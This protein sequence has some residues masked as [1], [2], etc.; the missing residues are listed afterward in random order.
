L[1]LSSEFRNQNFAIIL[2]EKIFKK[3]NSVKKFSFSF[4]KNSQKFTTIA[5]N[6]KGCLKLYTFIF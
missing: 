6:V 2:G 4:E 1:N 5:N 3:E